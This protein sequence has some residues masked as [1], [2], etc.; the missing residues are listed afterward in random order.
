MAPP[1]VPH[2]DSPFDASNFQVTHRS[3]YVRRV[4]ITDEACR[5]RGTR[6]VIMHAKRLLAALTSQLRPFACR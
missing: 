3:G 1:F 5:A 4:S 6:T 2:V